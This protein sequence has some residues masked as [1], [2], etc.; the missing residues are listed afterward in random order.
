M[1]I[2]G[3]LLHHRFFLWDKV[4]VFEFMI[5]FFRDNVHTML[6]SFNLPTGNTQLLTEVALTQMQ[7]LSSLLDEYRVGVV[8]E[9]QVFIH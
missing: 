3:A 2:G 9:L 1:K 4:N 8:N 7:L 5:L 6:P